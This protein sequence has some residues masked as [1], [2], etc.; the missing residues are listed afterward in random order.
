M[1]HTQG[2]EGGDGV[3]RELHAAGDTARLD[4][5]EL[6]GLKLQSQGIDGVPME[7]NCGETMRVD[8]RELSNLIEESSGIATGTP[9]AGMPQ[10]IDEPEI[11]MIAPTE[12]AR[13]SV[14]EVMPVPDVDPSR[15]E[16]AT[17]A[18]G[19]SRLQGFLIGA[20][21][22]VAGVIAWFCTTQL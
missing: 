22:A 19:S 6:H 11:E 10:F 9:M 7:M 14:S 16:T 21:V 17:I 18:P 13:G 12:F 5:R 15:E 8:T 3:V 2:D 1:R 20:A 4:R